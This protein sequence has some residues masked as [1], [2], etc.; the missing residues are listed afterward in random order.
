MK[1]VKYLLILAVCCILLG[2]GS[3]YGL[4]KYIEP[5]L[6][7]VNTLKD[8]RLQTPMQVYSADGELI[9]QYGEKRRIPLTLSQMPPELIKAFIATEDSRFYEHHGIDPIGI[10]RAASVALISGHA[11]QGA[12]T[13][14]QQLARNFFLSPERTLMRK[15]K[16]A[17]LAIRIEQ[18]LSKDEILELYLNKI[19]L[20]YRSYGVGAAAQVYFG[21]NIDRL[22]LSEMAMIAG[23][24]KAPST[25]NPLYSHARA[26]ARRNVVLS[27]MLAQNY[28]TQ[29]QYIEA[30]SE[31]LEASYH[32]PEIAF[33]A[34]YLTEMVRQEMLK[35]YGDNAYNDGFKVYTTVTHKLQL[36][37]QEAVRNNVLDYDMRHGYRGPANIL[38]R[39]GESAW[40][41]TRILKNLKTLPVYGPLWPAVVTTA[42]GNEATALMRDGSSVSLTMEGVRWARPYKSDTQQGATPRSVT[43]VLQPG[44]QIWVRKVENSWW[45]A[46]VPNVNSS[47]ISLDPHDGAVRALVGGFD[48]NQSKFNRVTQALR[49]VG[50][51]IKPFLYTAAMDRGLTLASILNDVPISRWDAGAGSDW[52][53]KNSPA[54]YD[55][56]I[57]LRQG[58]G[59][60]K[61]VVMVRAMRAMG[62]DYAAEYLQRFGFPAQNIV[63]TESLALGA[64]SFTPLQMARGYAVMANGGFLVD[65]YFIKKIESENGETLFENHPRI[66]CPECNLPVIYGETKKSVALGEESVENVAVSQENSHPAVPQPVLQ[67]VGADR[68]DATQQYAP[69]VINT[70]LS[71]LIKSAL[72]SN[73]FGEPGWMG[74]GWRAGRDLKRKDIGGKTGTT[75]SSK[76]AWFSGYGPG[77]VTT[78]WIGFDDHRRDL[79]RSTASGAIDDQISGY[80]GGA[81]SAQPAWDSF[82]K[83][84]L[85]G[86]PEQPLTP[87]PGVVTVT[88]DRS[89]GKLANG[90][91]NTRQ[92][93]FID[94]TQPTEYSVHDVGTTL[95]DNGETHELF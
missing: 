27:R 74:T 70:P 10:F 5:Q 88:I 20:G 14:T 44:Q 11:S 61:N 2:V 90:G 18:L 49:Q 8:V 83:A 75:N 53:P 37:A 80:E 73:I 79:G 91:G 23:L 85:D 95:M 9:A 54:T 38:W 21:K 93:Y 69:H 25:F 24:P 31:P 64:A 52:R 40:D 57:R 76:D 84:A 62:V 55:G 39:V 41:R 46:Q 59:Q 29:R 60:S 19:Y 89:T 12:S 63:H 3:V 81:K 36:A 50:S 17:F 86:V 78:V 66:A 34:P 7:D 47:L 72:N 42:N 48:F 13:I 58:L 33:S 92:E 77:V 26:L 30:R 56:P 15:I 43:Q 87:P 51:N 6:P 22:T 67:Q 65:P 4:Y 71:F 32:G 28:I 1:F 45:L 94:G 16:E 82:M 35:R 68:P